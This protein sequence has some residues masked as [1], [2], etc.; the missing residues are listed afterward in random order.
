MEE[1]VWEVRC[2]DYQNDIF[3]RFA[4]AV[5]EE[6][7]D[8]C[9]AINYDEFRFLAPK[10]YDDV[11]YATTVWSWEWNGETTAEE[12]R[13]RLVRVARRLYANRFDV[14]LKRFRD[15]VREIVK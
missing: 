1:N 8:V 4:V 5:V 13:E 9:L 2:V 6:K 10:Y 15:N 14:A 3:E 7:R 11:Y 12:M